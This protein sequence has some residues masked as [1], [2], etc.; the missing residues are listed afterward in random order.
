MKK[1]VVFT[2]ILTTILLSACSDR[3]SDIIQAAG[4]AAQVEK[5]LREKNEKCH[6]SAWQMV[7]VDNGSYSQNIYKLQNVS[8][9]REPILLVA[10]SAPSYCAF[11]KFKLESIQSHLELGESVNFS[12]VSKSLLDCAKASNNEVLREVAKDCNGKWF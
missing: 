1:T 9:Q 3:S 4:E 12:T 6:L 10:P 2:A 8:W 5:R 7:E 11:F